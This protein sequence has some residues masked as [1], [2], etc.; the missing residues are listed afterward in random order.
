[1]AG[2]QRERSGF[3]F[4]SHSLLQ[5]G[6]NHVVVVGHDVPRRLGLPSLRGHFI[7]KGGGHRLLGGNCPLTGRSAMALVLLPA[8]EVLLVHSLRSFADLSATD[9]HLAE[10]YWMPRRIA[11]NDFF[12]FRN[13]ICQHVA[14]VTKDLLRAHYVDA[15]AQEHDIFFV[16]EH[17]SSRLSK[18]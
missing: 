15:D 9:L 4:L 7:A 3:D 5:D 10:G 13:S 16:P 6:D 2:L 11:Q 8:P 18:A 12:N 14:F 17:F 1:V